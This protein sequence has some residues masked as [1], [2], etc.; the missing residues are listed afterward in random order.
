[1]QEQEPNYIKQVQIKGLWDKYD[2]NWEL[3]PDVNVLAGDNG[4]GKSTVLKLLRD[5]LMILSKLIAAEKS[6][7]IEKELKE[8]INY[9][10][11]KIGEKLDKQ[12]AQTLAKNTAF[13][14]CFLFD[15]IENDIRAIYL[16]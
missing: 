14:N 1:M 15:K 6:K 4:M 10:E 2:L 13:T 11:N 12:I 5:Y 3:N 16:Q 9:Y 8:N 7:K